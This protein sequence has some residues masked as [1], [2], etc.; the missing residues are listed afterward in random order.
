[1]RQDWI[2]DSRD[3][4]TGRDS[5]YP[6]TS[7]WGW[8]SGGISPASW[9][10]TV[11]EVDRVPG[12]R[13]REHSGVASSLGSMESQLIQE[14]IRCQ[15]DFFMEATRRLGEQQER[16]YRRLMEREP[17]GN[18]GGGMRSRDRLEPEAVAQIMLFS[19][20]GEEEATLWIE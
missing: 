3:G 15:Q 17:Q 4:V 18:E 6:G 10:R 19:G 11:E 2:V 12:T 8:G 13:S 16:V 20:K 7:G 5:G 9:R 14:M 1:M